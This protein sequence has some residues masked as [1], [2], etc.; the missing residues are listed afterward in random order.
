MSRPPAADPIRCASGSRKLSSRPRRPTTRV[1]PSWTAIMARMPSY[2]I[3]NHHPAREKGWGR[4]LAS[5]AEG[6]TSGAATTGARLTT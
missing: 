6:M 1:V 2:F 5:M 3:S 4:G